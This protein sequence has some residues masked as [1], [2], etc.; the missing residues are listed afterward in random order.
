MVSL[1]RKKAFVPGCTDVFEKSIVLV[2]TRGGVPVFKRNV[3]IPAL[4]KLSDRDCIVGC[5]SGPDSV[6]V[7]PR[8]TEEDIYVPVVKT[9]VFP[10]N[11]VPSVH[12]TPSI[13]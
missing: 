6:A 9:T 13:R 7:C 3:R 12:R 5:S 11:S 2:K 8:N 4:R 10:N 1:K